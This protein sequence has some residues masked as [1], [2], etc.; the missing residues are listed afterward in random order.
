MFFY[1]QWS[2]L[3]ILA[4]LPFMFLF[5]HKS[6]DMALYLHLYPDPPLVIVLGFMRLMRTSVYFTSTVNDPRRTHSADREQVKGYNIPRKQ[7]NY[8]T[9]M[10]SVLSH[11]RESRPV[12]HPEECKQLGSTIHLAWQVCMKNTRF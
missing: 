11:Y 6:S 10:R 7:P 8:S 1:L 12:S 5:P 4:S 2:V 9:A 3:R